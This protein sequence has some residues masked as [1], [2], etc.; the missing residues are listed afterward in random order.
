MLLLLSMVSLAA[1]QDR[2]QATRPEPVDPIFWADGITQVDDLDA[3]QRAGLNTVIVRLTWTPTEGGALLTE[4]LAPQHAFANAAAK[5]G[6]KV[7]YALPPAPTGQELNFRVSA[8]SDSY[9]A[10]WTT[11]IQAAI[12]ELKDTRNLLGWMLPDDPRGLRLYDDR[13][14]QSWVQKHFANIV[15]VNKQWKANYED[16]EDVTLDSVSA[17]ATEWR[18]LGT[19]PADMAMGEVYERLQAD[20]EKAPSNGWA[21]HPASLAVAHYKW[22]TYRTLLATWIQVIKATDAQ[23]KIYSGLTPD[24]AQL[25]ALPPGIDVSMPALLPGQAEND[26]VTH[27]PQG[28][29]IARRGGRFQALPLLTTAP[30][31]GLPADALADLIPRWIQ[32]SCARGAIGVGF[33]SWTSLNGDAALYKSVADALLRLGQAPYDRLWGNGPVNTAAILLT[34]LADGA[35]VQFG[36][37][38]AQMP[39]GIYG[40]GE[41]MVTGEPSDLVWEMRWGTAYGGFDY[42]SPDDLETAPLDRYATILLP[43]A[44]SIST[45][46]TARLA[47]FVANGGCIVADLGLGATQNGCQVNGFSPTLAALFGVSPP[48]EINNLFFNV[49]GMTQHPLFPSWAR[50]VGIRPGLVV[51]AGDGKDNSAFTGPVG[52]TPAPPAA[53]ML[54]AAPQLAGTF[55]AN[56]LVSRAGITVNGIGQGYAV[57]APFRLWNHWRPG[58]FGFDT[59]HGDLLG[60]G[61]LAAVANVNSLVPLPHFTPDGSTLFPEL[62]NHTGGLVLAN[63]AAPGLNSE[64]CTIRTSGTGDWLWRGA[65]VLLPNATNNVI[66]GGRPAPAEAANELESRSRDVSLYAD[67]KPGDFDFL[68]MRP[69]AVQNL[70]GGPVVGEIAEENPQRL[71]VHIWPNSPGV[72][73][74]E[75]KWQPILRDACPTRVTVVSS[76]DGYAFPPASRHRVVI[77]D[78]AKGVDKKGRYSIQEKLVQAGA[79]GRL[80]FEFSGSACGVE[81]TPLSAANAAMEKRR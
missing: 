48:F 58:H 78:Y 16:F 21:F 61:A 71:E 23:H 35:T 10:L 62:L 53:A 54:A 52:Y 1:A 44:F 56:R 55:T 74:S 20:R 51:T 66:T 30:T 77:T 7:I 49:N 15:S 38:P 73:V 27:N 3:Y 14:F 12:L 65:I 29:D 67:L 36:T 70:A 13:S 37:P 47:S 19:P 39:R 26:I 9:L 34:P 11:W 28:I 72:L 63:H 69:I 24:Y 6:L 60:R 41:D 80:V 43:Q 17:I 33:S 50:S 31:A 64:R 46:M 5:R 79:D 2:E 8:E 68:A 57:F 22:D 42:L 18:G 25:L 4:D 45:D 75:D 40:F 76:P 32:E 59:F 81:V